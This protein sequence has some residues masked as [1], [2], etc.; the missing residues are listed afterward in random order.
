MSRRQTAIDMDS[1]E[2]S[3]IANSTPGAPRAARGST[4][5]PKSMESLLA[6]IFLI[7]V[8]LLI[9]IIAIELFARF[10]LWQV[11]SEE[12]FRFLASIAQIKDR[13]GDDFFVQ[14]EETS[15][16]SWSPHYFLG[17]Y[18]TPNHQAGA[19]RHNSLGFRGREFAVS[20]PENVYRIVTLGGSTTYSSGVDDFELSYP[21]LL[22][23]YL[24]Q[25]GFDAVEVINAG[26]SGYT[27]HQNLINMQFR[28]LPL[29]PDLIIVYQGFND[30]QARFVYPASKY[31]GDRSGSL[32]PFVSGIVMPDVTEY[33]TALRIL[34]IRLGATAS[35]SALDWHLSRRP[36]SY[37]GDM[38][39]QQIQLGTYPSGIFK[40]ISAAEILENNPPV[41]FERNT[42][43]MIALA[44][45]SDVNILQ[46][47]MAFDDDFHQT[48]GRTTRRFSTSD[49]F[50][51]AMA[52]HNALTRDIGA[53][54]D[55][56]V[57]D[58]AAIFPDDHTLFT[59]G[60]HMTEKGNR[61]RAQ[62]IGDFVIQQ[63]SQE[64]HAAASP[65]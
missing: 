22:E 48:S 37:V 19:N 11:A 45:Q 43:Y 39:I 56:P 54:Y 46:V 61:A 12:E 26:A 40:E 44:N 2:S 32:R 24:R 58:L 3:V 5:L 10:Y 18:P 36:N 20:K 57:F 34:G 49:E 8:S 63:F 33:S 35:H 14:N 38:Y 21:D 23:D 42:E 30:I 6:K 13:Y 31:L 47:T 15:H 53:R 50:V 52:R 65:P 1:P 51:S 29:L 62:L 41:H 17:F 60:L 64:M 55:S 16:R 4:R 7:L 25:G 9:C 28:V 59:D 27:S